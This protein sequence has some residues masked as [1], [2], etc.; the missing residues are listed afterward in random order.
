MKY[1]IQGKKDFSVYPKDNEGVQLHVLSDMFYLKYHSAVFVN[2]TDV[3][4]VITNQQELKSTD[5]VQV[6]PNALYKVDNLV[7]CLSKPFEDEDVQNV[8]YLLRDLIIADEQQILSEQ[9]ITNH[10]KD[11]EE[12][13]SFVLTENAIK[14]LNNILS[15]EKLSADDTDLIE[16]ITTTA[17]QLLDNLMDDTRLIDDIV[18]SINY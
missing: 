10:V 7:E 3:S 11:I 4:K 14:E 6:T 17:Q 16:Y 1:L 2:V 15:N 8:L 13:T 12:Y 18:S 5:W 9:D